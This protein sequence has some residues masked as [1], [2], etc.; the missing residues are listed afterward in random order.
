[1][2]GQLTYVFDLF[3]DIVLCSLE[4]AL[5]CLCGTPDAPASTSSML[6]L[7]ACVTH[8]SGS[9]FLYGSNM[10]EPGRGSQLYTRCT[11]LKK[12]EGELCMS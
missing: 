4:L 5:S 1:M 10:L 12:A 7:W 11:G 6:G 2:L 8:G 3:L 9:A